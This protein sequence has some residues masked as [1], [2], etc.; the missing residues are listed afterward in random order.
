MLYLAAGYPTRSPHP[1]SLTS[2]LQSIRFISLINRGVSHGRGFSS[3]QGG[4]A[5]VSSHIL[6]ARY[7][8]PHG[9]GFIS[10]NLLGHSTDSAS[11]HNYLVPSTRM[12]DCEKQFIIVYAWSINVNQLSFL[13][14]SACCVHTSNTRRRCK[15][16]HVCTC[17]MKG[18]DN[19]ES[20]SPI[21]ATNLESD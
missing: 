20:L 3:T 4:F 15:A 7:A 12:Q 1:G 9:D 6:N 18:H 8:Q 21:L 14:S 17:I 16:A 2:W 10:F 13:L 19:M 5:Q 11:T